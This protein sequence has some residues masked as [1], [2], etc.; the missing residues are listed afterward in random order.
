MR[1]APRLLLFVALA[2]L[3]AAACRGRDDG[4]TVHLNGRIEA[5]LVDLAPKVSG[6]VVEVLV[7]EGDRVKAGQVLARLD[8]GDTALD[9]ERDT[10][11]VRSAEAK[12]QDLASGSRRAEI[13]A[14][15][16]EVA[17]RLAAVTLARR[18]LERQES[19]LSQKIGTARDHD[20]ARTDLARAEAVLKASEERHRLALEGFRRHQTEAARFDAGRAKVELRQSETVAKEAEILA[21]ADGVIL[22]RMA[23]PGLLLAAGQPAVTMAFANRLYV[24]TF[25]PETK[26]GLVRQGQSAVVKVDTFPDRTFPARVAEI[27]PDAEF[28][29]K[30]VETR[31]ERVNLVYTTKVD[32]LDGWEA[33]LVPGQPAEVIVN[34]EG[35]KR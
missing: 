27:S 25:V 16:A 22:H 1:R 2:A 13:A 4:K 33:P 34:V 18:E 7:R 32:L 31:S 15:E 35:E 24:R 11:G 30:A 3:A 28:T 14:V 19:L 23:E 20:V 29:P 12:Y 6:R 5:P 26:L 8:L 17:D 10:Q 21:P 9:V